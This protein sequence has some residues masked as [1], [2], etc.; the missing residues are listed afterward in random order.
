MKNY[1]V[2]IIA[3]MLTACGPEKASWGT[4]EDMRKIAKQNGEFSADAFRNA[5]FPDLIV[6]PNGDST[7]NEDCP[8]GDGWVSID[9]LDKQTQ[10]VKVEL[11]CSSVSMEIGCYEK[12]VFQT[13]KDYAAQDGRCNNAIP[14]PLPK[15]VK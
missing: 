5:Y 1:Y 15:L 14:F 8:Q 9:L 2:L 13:K 12:A 7:I 6:R 10:K 4:Q 3:A 11:K